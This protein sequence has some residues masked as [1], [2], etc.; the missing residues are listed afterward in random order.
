DHGSGHR[1]R[2]RDALHRRLRRVLG[3][4]AARLAHVRGRVTMPG[5][6]RPTKQDTGDT[7]ALHPIG[8]GGVDYFNDPS[9]L[10]AS[11]L[12]RSENLDLTSGTADRRKGAL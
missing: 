3:Q 5:P 12:S 1:D 9:A 6:Y 7:V 8:A 11:V 10:D 4:R 2:G